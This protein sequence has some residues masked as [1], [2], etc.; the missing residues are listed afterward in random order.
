MMGDYSGKRLFWT[1]HAAS[2]AIEDNFDP[3]EIEKKL[4]RVCEVPEFNEGKRRGTIKVD[5]R[6]CTLTYKKKKS[7]LVVITCWE[8][9]Q[10]DIKEYRR[11]V[12]DKGK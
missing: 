4:K 6:Y 10:T 9:N 3:E 11:K 7:G 1:K 12:R 8:S 5:S 2:E